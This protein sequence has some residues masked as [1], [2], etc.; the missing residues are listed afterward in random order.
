ME[1]QKTCCFFGH[2]EIWHDDLTGPLDEAVKRHIVECGVGDFLVGHYG[3]FDYLAAQ[4][5]KKAK[6]RHP[7]VRLFLMLPYLPGHGRPLPRDMEGFDDTV[8]PEGLEKVPRRLAILRLNRMI[9]QQ[10][11]YAIAYITHTWGGAAATMEMAQRRERRGEMA[12]TNL[13][14]LPLPPRNQ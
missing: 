14:A 8:Y 11:D 10:S 12:I 1:G 13:G 5:V 2:N 6:A 9:V 7:G 3:R 4:A